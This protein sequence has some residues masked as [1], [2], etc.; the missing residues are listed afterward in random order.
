MAA[1]ELVHKSG[2][3]RC[4]TDTRQYSSLGALNLVAQG[5]AQI[6]GSTGKPPHGSRNQSIN[7]LTAELV[8]RLIGELVSWLTG[9]PTKWLAG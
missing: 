7:W 2:G 3:P 4:H 8:G 1:Y 9:S 6:P 5:A